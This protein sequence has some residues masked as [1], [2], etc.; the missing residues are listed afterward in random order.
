MYGK[1]SPC[2]AIEVFGKYVRNLHVKDGIPPVDGDKL[3]KEVQVGK[4]FVNFP[5]LLPRLKELGFDG[6]LIIER[7]IR[8]GAEQN[9]DIMETVG[10]IRNWWN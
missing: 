2:D 6:D 10:N 1:G 3:G 9:R 7:E 5:R 4:G 8:E